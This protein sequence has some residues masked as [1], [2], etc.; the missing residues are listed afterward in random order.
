MAS[1]FHVIVI[2][3]GT[4][5]MCLAHGLRRAGIGVAVYERDRTRSDGLYGY[6]VGIDP[7]GSRALHQCLPP[8]LYETFVATCARAPR[9]FNMLDEHFDEVLSL[10]LRDDTDPVDSEKSV[11][12][13]TLR[14]VLLTGLEDAVHFGKDFQRYQT[15]PDGTVTAFFADGTSATGDLLV[16]ADGT[17]SRVRRQ[18]LPHARVVPSGIVAISAKVPLTDETRNLL[19][20][21]VFF[22]I[23][24]IFAPKGFFGI[25]HV[26]EFPWDRAG[27]VKGGIG[28]NDA[29][30][31][32]QWPGLL[33]D[34]TRDYINWGFAASTR[35]LPG[36]VLSL[37]GP[38]LVTV[39]RE[40]TPTWS[41][42][43]HTL[44]DRTDTSTCVPIDV[45]T[46]E[47]I[48]A[49]PTTNVT[50]LGDAIHTMTPGRG[51]GANTALR[52]AALLTRR[53]IDARDGRLSLL[54]AVHRY[55]TKMIDYGFRAVLDS[56]KQQGGD[57]PMHR[58]VIGRLALAG[59]RTAM[60]TVNHLPPLKKKMTDDLYRYR[61]FERDDD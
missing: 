11:S 23:S 10:R 6:R 30:L 50:L 31:I 36:D 52:D 25:L 47:P 28:G 12:R 1:P 41:P 55:E 42:T 56:R 2:G 20:P 54:E 49:W 32:A 38:E 16:A 35:W 45:A 27:R 19:P 22:G 26:M 7:D 33:Y 53:L 39:V 24:T 58:P 48:P 46:S 40:L 5:G 51:V 59:M 14:Q 18:Y 37:S 60:R 3:A 15:N 43:F 8:D 44:L 13:M 29:E 9:Y 21:K 57:N 34:N 4:G 61:G 17:R